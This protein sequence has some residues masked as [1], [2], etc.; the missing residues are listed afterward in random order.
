MASSFA[1]LGVPDAIVQAL[2]DRG[3]TEPFEVQA[4]TIPDALAGRDVCG[5]APTGSGKTLA[6]GIPLVATVK[7]AEPRHPVALILAPTRELANQIMTELIPLAQPRKRFV[8]A[9]YGGVNIDRHI[10]SLR[11]GVD[12][13]VACPG[14]LEDLISRGAVSLESVRHVVLDE[15]DRMADMGFMPSVRRILDQCHRNRQTLLFSATLDGDV[16]TLTRDY[17]KNPV[18][19][20]VGSAEPDIT[21]MTHLFWNATREDRLDITAEVIHRAGPTIVFVRT[22][23]GADRIARKLNNAGVNSVAIH[24]N[25]S[26]NQRERALRSF[27]RGEAS[28]LIATDVAARGVHVDGVTCVVHFDP[29]NDHKDYVHRS[30]RTARAGAEGVVIS[31]LQRN[32][33]PDARKMQKRLGL[34]V[35]VTDA[36]ASLVP[37]HAGPRKP[38]SKQSRQESQPK[39]GSRQPNRDQKER[40]RHQGREKRPSTKRR[41][42]GTDQRDDE[43]PQESQSYG[44]S[45]TTPGPKRDKNRKRDAASRKSKGRPRRNKSGHS[46]PGTAKKHRAANKAGKPSGGSARGGS[47]RTSS[48]RTR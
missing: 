42:G 36:D 24:G 23:H 33:H 44:G 47:G 32:Q 6:F 14:R 11:K 37:K 26:Q 7:K 10:K 28:A 13:L 21:S 2:A 16:A 1:D 45:N 9:V 41:D 19:H 43:R 39:P 25:R 46:K 27:D 22:K 35:E 30:G 48:K 15:A 34:T 31:L 3:I 5:R 18:R 40:A 8:D 4:A 29:P 20:E 17:Q 38:K 12:I